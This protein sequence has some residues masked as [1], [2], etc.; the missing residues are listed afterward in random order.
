MQYNLLKLLLILALFSS[1]AAIEKKSNTE[2]AAIPVSKEVILTPEEQWVQ[3]TM[4]S[5]TLPQKVGQMI[6]LA[7]MAEV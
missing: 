5:M 1:G 2:Y 3:D 7:W 4:E 6:I